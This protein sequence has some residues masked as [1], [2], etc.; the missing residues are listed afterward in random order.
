MGLTELLHMFA[1][2]TKADLN[3]FKYWRQI[4][5]LVAELIGHKHLAPDHAKEPAKIYLSEEPFNG[6][7]LVF[8]E[9]KMFVDKGIIVAL[10]F[11]PLPFTLPH[12]HNI[13]STAPQVI[14]YGIVFLPTFPKITRHRALG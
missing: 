7:V 2:V 13:I 14:T 5:K 4:C 3:V 11:E 1:N 12:L 6:H 9:L 10:V 8:G